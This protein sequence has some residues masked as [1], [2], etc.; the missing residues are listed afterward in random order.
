MVLVLSP[1]APAEK[2][3]ASGL[4]SVRKL[5]KSP[6]GASSKDSTIG[7]APTFSKDS[8]LLKYFNAWYLLTRIYRSKLTV[9]RS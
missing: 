7:L 9:Y 1:A 3:T 2:M 4:V 6:T 5:V 8:E